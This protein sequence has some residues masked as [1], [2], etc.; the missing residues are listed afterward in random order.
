MGRKEKKVRLDYVFFFFSRANAKFKS[1]Y[2][3]Q[4]FCHALKKNVCIVL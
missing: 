1:S 2:I 4:F 3:L